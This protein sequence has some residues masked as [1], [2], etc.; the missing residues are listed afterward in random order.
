MRPHSHIY[1]Q[2]W[3]H[4]QKTPS[5]SQ[6]PVERTPRVYI[7]VYFVAVQHNDDQTLRLNM[8]LA[9]LNTKLAKRREIWN[10]QAKDATKKKNS[11]KKQSRSTAKVYLPGLTPVVTGLQ[12]PDCFRSQ[13]RVKQQE[14]NCVE[15]QA[16]QLRYR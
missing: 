16:K 15:F 6:Y 4:T 10:S 1:R 2:K 7:S 8:A 9:I 3:V 11:K 12:T 13:S 14:L 5:T